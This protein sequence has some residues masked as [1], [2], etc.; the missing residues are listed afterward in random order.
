M[1]FL[2]YEISNTKYEC[3]VIGDN[4]EIT[5]LVSVSNLPDN[6]IS[7]NWN[8][9][10]KADDIITRKAELSF[11]KA[12]DLIYSN[13]DWKFKIDVTDDENM[14]ENAIV[15]VTVRDFTN[16]QWYYKICSFNEHALSCAGGT[17]T[18][19]SG[20]T[21]ERIQTQKQ[22]QSIGSVTWKNVKLL[23]ID[24]PLNY[25]FTTFNNAFGGFFTEK[26]KIITY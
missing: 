23:H 5:D 17:D 24:I 19:A 3:K 14:P 26:C 6:D 11:V 20:D 4:Q 12:H 16:L 7:L 8:G 15:W 13:R 10:L 21:L 22:R 9:K 25:T 2:N 18:S 1:L